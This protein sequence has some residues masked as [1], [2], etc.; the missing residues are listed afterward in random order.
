MKRFLVALILAFALAGVAYATTTPSG[1][2]SRGI[3]GCNNAG[4]GQVGSRTPISAHVPVWDYAVSLNTNILVYKECVLDMVNNKFKQAAIARITKSGLEAIIGIQ[5]GDA[6]FVTNVKAYFA[7]KRDKRFREIFDKETQNICS[8]FKDKLKNRLEKDYRIS[9]N[10]PYEAFSCTVDEAR[11]EACRNGDL[12]GC[13]GLSGLLQFVSNPSNNAIY[14]YFKTKSY[15][16]SQLQ[17]E[18][19]LNKMQLDWGRGFKPKTQTESITLNDGTVV[20]IEK[21][22]TPGYLIAQ[23]ASDLI[24]TGLRQMENADEINEIIGVL[25]RN[26]GTQVVADQGGF[27]GLALGSDSYGSYLD[28]I[29]EESF[30]GARDAFVQNAIDSLNSAIKTQQDMINALERVLQA[31]VT[32]K[33]EVRALEMVC[34]EKLLEEGERQAKEELC[35]S[36]MGT[37]T[38]CAVVVDRSYDTGSVEVYESA[39]ERISASGYARSSTSSVEISFRSGGSVAGKEKVS[40]TGEYKKITGSPQD[41]SSL[42]DGNIRPYVKEG[43]FTSLGQFIFQ[44]ETI[45]DRPLYKAPYDLPD[46]TIIATSPTTTVSQ[47]RKVYDLKRD[48]GQAVIESSSNATNYSQIKEIYQYIDTINQYIVSMQDAKTRI[49]EEQSQ[50]AI[51]EAENLLQQVNS[52]AEV[53]IFTQQMNGQIARISEISDNTR[54]DW[55]ANGAW[56]SSDKNTLRSALAK[57]RTN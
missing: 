4:F 13:G 52:D 38:G 14:A 15:V 18:E 1:L 32:E 20:D 37:T 28:N 34:I 40:P 41:L 23:Y 39:L 2:T 57:Y 27:S 31:I 55:T 47:L 19:Y 11:M 5:N 21:V 51:A 54:D 49:L 24:G 26:I 56:C 10:K 30:G 44:K 22:V 36:S 25:M 43:S 33:N 45:G 35:L 46:V 53:V 3:M 12:E 42:A 16:G 17:R 9:A 6:Q 50:E 48:H 7:D 29:I 8:P